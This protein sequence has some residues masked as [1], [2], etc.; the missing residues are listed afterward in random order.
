MINKE[1][2]DLFSICLVAGEGGGEKGASENI[3]FSL[4]AWGKRGG[5][6]RDLRICVRGGTRSLSSPKEGKEKGETCT[7]H[8]L[9]EARLLPSSR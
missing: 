6:Q 4:P 1:G 8:L 3:S 2:D 7:F 5:V 9:G